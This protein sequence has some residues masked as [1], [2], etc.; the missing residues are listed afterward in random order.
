VPTTVS[1]F[2]NTQ[3]APDQIAWLLNQFD[4]LQG[5]SGQSW[6][7]EVGP[8][9]TDVVDV[10]D[11]TDGLASM[12]PELV[13]AAAQWL[14]G[15][16]QYRLALA[17]VDSPACRD[18]AW[19]IAE[20]FA[21]WCRLCGATTPAAPNRLHPWGRGGS[22]SS[23]TTNPRQPH[24]PRWRMSPPPSAR[25]LLLGR[26]LALAPSREMIDPPPPGAIR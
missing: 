24:H 18:L 21:R 2:S 15:S 4:A 14:G 9:A 25:T 26:S 6:I 10:A 3:I 17:I 20:E 22:A 5:P 12:P 1:V 19:R 8:D 23:V 13:D 11:G 7:I 16:P